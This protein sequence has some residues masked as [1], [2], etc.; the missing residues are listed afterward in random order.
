MSR[1]ALEWLMPG[2]ADRLTHVMLLD[3][4]RPAPY[5]LAVGHGTDKVHALLNLWGALKKDTAETEAIAFVAAE[6]RRRTGLFRKRRR[7][8]KARE[9][10]L[11]APDGR[12]PS[13]FRPLHRAPE[14]AY[15]AI[16][17]IRGGQRCSVTGQRS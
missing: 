3:R 2:E 14:G 4:E 15:R 6:Y 7:P 8:D 5:L 1:F 17:A 11:L 16:V 10:W 9:G 12:S 13:T